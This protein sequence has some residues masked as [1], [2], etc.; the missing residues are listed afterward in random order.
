[1]LPPPPSDLL[2]R[3]FL[4]RQTVLPDRVVLATVGVGVVGVAGV[5]GAAGTV[6]AAVAGGV[7]GVGAFAGGMVACG[8]GSGF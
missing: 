4:G 8:G 7:A 5:A 6:E 3:S 2:E 1:M